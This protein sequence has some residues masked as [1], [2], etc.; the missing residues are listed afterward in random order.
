MLSTKQ[1]MIDRVIGVTPE[2]FLFDHIPLCRPTV[3]A[4]VVPQWNA[5]KLWTKEFFK[6]R[7]G[8]ILVTVRNSQDYEDKHVLPL[9]DYILDLE[10]GGPMSAYY[11]KDW[12]FE[13]D[14]PELKEHYHLPK[15]L[16]S[17]TERLPK[18][19]RPIWRW[20]FVGPPNTASH[21]HVDFLN[22]SAWNALFLGKKRWIFFQPDDARFLYRGKVNAFSPELEKFP[23]FRYA[24]PIPY[25]QTPGELVITPGGWWHA[26]QNEEISVA[27]SEN[28]INRTNILN[29]LSVSVMY[30]FFRFADHPWWVA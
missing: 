24:T 1:N 12:R 7:Y 25:T 20:I 2:Q 18:S 3:I 16:Y 9:R 5:A 11:L 23:L 19:I 10:T 30:R 17:W 8:N 14:C 15:Y 29:Y 26:V 21:L 27:L 13:F 28:F 6:S 4:D 22:T